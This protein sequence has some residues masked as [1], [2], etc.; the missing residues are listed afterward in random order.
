MVAGHRIDDDAVSRLLEPVVLV[1]A[2]NAA[3]DR[4]FLERRLTVFVNRH[5]ACSRSD[6]GWRAEGI[7]SSA[8]EFIAYALG[9]LHDGHRAVSDCGATLHV[10]SKPLPQSGRFALAALLERARTKTWRLWARDAPIET[11]DALKARGYT[12]SPGDFGR[13]R[14][15]FRDVPDAEKLSEVEWLRTSV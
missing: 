6:I 10:L 15:W 4:R 14:C 1:I 2:H 5:W 11:K 3:F 8:L 12:W 9:F 7:R 13:P